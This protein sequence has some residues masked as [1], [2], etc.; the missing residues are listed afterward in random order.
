MTYKKIYPLGKN[1]SVGSF[2]DFFSKDYENIEQAWEK[3]DFVVVDFV[4]DEN[5]IRY[6][7]FYHIRTP[8]TKKHHRLEIQHFPFGIDVFDDK[9][10]CEIAPTLFL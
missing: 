4:E 9:S 7:E 8:E 2:D 1:K 10:A 3:N 5:E 6:F